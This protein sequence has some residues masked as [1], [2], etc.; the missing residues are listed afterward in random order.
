MK[1]S[2][3]NLVFVK[4]IFIYSHIYYLIGVRCL[5]A[6][7]SNLLFVIC[8][9]KY[10]LIGVHELTSFGCDFLNSFI[11]HFRFLDTTKSGR[12]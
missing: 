9:H 12:L 1:L 7:G 11:I 6:L 5:A 3:L 10:N 4:L 2:V 8:S